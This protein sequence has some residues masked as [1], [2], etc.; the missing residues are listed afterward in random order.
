MTTTD[1]PTVPGVPAAPAGEARVDRIGFA[2]MLLSGGSAQSGAAVAA[3]GF[4][5]LGPVGV[6]AIRQWVAAVAMLAVARPRLRDWTVREWRPVLALALVFVVINVSLY[7]A[8]DRVGL[9]LAVTLEFLGPL[10][11]ALASSRRRVDIGCA[12]AAATGV[13]VLTRPQPTT[14]YVGIA[15]AFVAA[16]CWAA[17]IMVN[18]TVGRR[19]PGPA[20]PAVAQTVSALVYIP[21]GVLALVHGHPTWGAV[22]AAASA[23]VLCSA[24]PFLADVAALRRVPARFFGVFM[25][26]SPV[27]AAAAGWVVLGQGL[28]WS[29]WLAIGVI[30]GANVVNALTTAR[31]ARRQPP[32]IAPMIR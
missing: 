18:R 11:V 31:A 1:A 16:A 24:V 19:V 4:P 26:V 2:L 14:D 17:Y 20:G 13:V 6:V 21:L 9:G 15:L 10:S 5:A 22:G 3:L 28:A 12:L 30:V 7:T 23:G 29:A 32:A 8:V 27:F 25:S